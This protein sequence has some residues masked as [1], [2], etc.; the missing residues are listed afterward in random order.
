MQTHAAYITAMK[1][2]LDVLN[3]QMNSL[4]AKS[5]DAQQTVHD[6]YEKELVKVRAQSQL[7]L[8]KLHEM[9]TAGETTWG[10]MVTDM[11]KLRDAFTSS[12]HYFKAQL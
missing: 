1:H 3:D 7:A 12:F 9:Q 10:S 8:A 6:I 2:Q 4:E 5:K 11:E